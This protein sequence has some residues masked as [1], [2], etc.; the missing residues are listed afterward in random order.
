MSD[1]D[2]RLRQALHDLAPEDP[3][4]EGLADGARRYAARTRRVRQLGVATAA[5]ATLALATVLVASY[6]PPARVVPA[7]PFLTPADCTRPLQPEAV[8]TADGVDTTVAVAAWVCPDSAG[9]ASP[10]STASA[11]DTAD[12]WRLP[13]EAITGR[14]LARL[15]LV[16]RD[17]VSDCGTVRPGPAFTV[18][19]ESVGGAL[20][21][22][23]SG[24]LACGGAHTLA[25]VFAALAD[26]EAD[27]RAA[28]HGNQAL[29]CRSDETWLRT[30]KP[31][32]LSHELRSPLVTASLCLVPTF[33]AGDPASPVQ[34]LTARSYRSIRLPAESLALLNADL[35]ADWGGFFTGNGGCGGEGRWT[36]AILGV[37]DA[38]D[39]RMLTTGCLDELWVRGVNRTGFIPSAQTTAALRALVPPS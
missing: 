25:S 33:L 22:Y 26:E 7:G 38:G 8:P 12:G 37:T 19:L 15:N 11:A 27:A 3:T 39:E 32:S 23:R 35:T 29:D 5:A 18:T 2:T 13:P 36:Y 16:G 21:S 9:A 17:V 14:H 30:R 4:T 6:D 10:T 28:A 31:T 20:T 34:P 24:E 1:L